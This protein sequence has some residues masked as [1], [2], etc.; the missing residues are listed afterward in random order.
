M[1][2]TKAQIGL[3]VGW[4]IAV[5]AL[6]ASLVFLEFAWNFFSWGVNLNVSNMLLIVCMI[7]G[8]VAIWFLAGKLEERKVA[9]ISLVLLLGLFVFGVVVFEGRDDNNRSPAWYHLSRLVLM[10]LPVMFW[11]RGCVRLRRRTA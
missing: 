4:I 6:Y 5:G 7:L 11:F 1:R 3:I 2:S 10:A 9:V 8:L